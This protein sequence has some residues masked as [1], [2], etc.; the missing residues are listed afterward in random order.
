M[1]YEPDPL[2]LREQAPPSAAQLARLE[3]AG[4][5][6]DEVKCA[7][8]A[9]RLIDTIEKRR[10]EGLATPKQIRC[11]ERYGF[12]GVGTWA[13]AEANGMITRIAANGWTVPYNINP[14]DYQ[15]AGGA[16]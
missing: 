14:R 3:K 11:L 6:P 8:H 2:N 9:S 13:F 16:T 10:M 5:Y 1:E 12:L 4:I 7:G 15:P